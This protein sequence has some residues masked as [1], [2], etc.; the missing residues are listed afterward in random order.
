MNSDQRITLLTSRSLSGL[1][2]KVKE[3]FLGFG[4]NHALVTDLDTELQLILQQ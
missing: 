4:H 1:R 3:V 2:H